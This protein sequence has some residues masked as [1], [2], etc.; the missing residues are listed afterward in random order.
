[1]R[2]ARKYFANCNA[3]MCRSLLLYGMSKKGVQLHSFYTACIDGITLHFDSVDLIKLIMGKQ[4]F[5]FL[6]VI[7]RIVGFE[8]L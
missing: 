6:V 2:S 7:L 4:I 5:I 3:C 1:M 8:L